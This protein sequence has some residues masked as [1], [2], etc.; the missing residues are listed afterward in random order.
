MEENLAEAG[1]DIGNAEVN[2]DED[3]PSDKEI[4]TIHN[5]D[6]KDSAENVNDQNL[7]KDLENTSNSD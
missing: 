2:I 1:V 4:D 5:A 3:I 6:K 7:N